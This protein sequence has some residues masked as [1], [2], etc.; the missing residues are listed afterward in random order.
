[1]GAAQFAHPEIEN[2]D[3]DG[4]LAIQKRKLKALGERL[5][6][7]PEWVR[8][9]RKAQMSP[10]DLADLDHS[11][12]RLPWIRPTLGRSTRFPC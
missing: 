12:Q 6:H 1:M 10:R 9:F 4:I 8:H 2:L 11:H 3:R 5:Q 7:A